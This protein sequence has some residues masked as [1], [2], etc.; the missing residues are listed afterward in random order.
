[1]YE[2]RVSPLH[3]QMDCCNVSEVSQGCLTVLMT[4]LSVLTTEGWMMVA[5]R[6]TATTGG[7][8]DRLWGRMYTVCATH[9]FVAKRLLHI[10]L[11][12]ILI[13]L[14]SRGVVTPYVFPV[15]LCVMTVPSRGTH[16]RTGRGPYP[17]RYDSSLG[18]D[19]FNHPRFKF[20]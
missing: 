8:T 10:I 7:L 17:T 3:D 9:D 19:L 1:M 15:H 6:G 20:L 11:E 16:L 12:V 4:S 5:P 2:V 18:S 14:F 13:Q